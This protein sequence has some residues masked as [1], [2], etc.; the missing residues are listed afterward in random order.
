MAENTEMQ[1]PKTQQE[2]F[3]V[4]RVMTTRLSTSAAQAET[5]EDRTDESFTEITDD[6]SEAF[7]TLAGLIIQTRSEI[8][9]NKN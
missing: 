3:G 7:Y 8:L 6:M 1:I 4:I 2:L 5:Q 9:L